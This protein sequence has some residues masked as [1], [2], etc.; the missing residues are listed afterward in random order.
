MP[1]NILKEAEPLLKPIPHGIPI[2]KRVQREAGPVEIGV[3]GLSR[4]L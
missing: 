1:D 4:F 3:G 2:Y